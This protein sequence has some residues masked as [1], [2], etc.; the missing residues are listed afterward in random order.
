MLNRY[1]E[2]YIHGKGHYMNTFSEKYFAD[3]AAP[4]N[5]SKANA[6]MEKGPM[7]ERGPIS[8][9]CIVARYDE[10]FFLMSCVKILMDGS[11]PWWVHVSHLTVYSRL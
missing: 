4:V 6:K 11:T 10:S 3:F 1:N 5:F 7:N 2:T 8:Y 9:P